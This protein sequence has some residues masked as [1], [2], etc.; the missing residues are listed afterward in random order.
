MYKND[1]CTSEELLEKDNSLTI[2]HRNLQLLATKMYKMKNNLSPD[3]MK[4]IFLEQN[5]GYH[6]RKE[7]LWETSNIQTAQWGSETRSFR[8]TMTRDLIPNKLKNPHLL[9]NLRQK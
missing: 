9:M 5:S 4:Q 2:H 7:K 8:G 3:I 1:E 6:L